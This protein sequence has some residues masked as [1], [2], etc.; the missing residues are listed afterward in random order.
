MCNP[1]ADAINKAFLSDL[2]KGVKV[3]PTVMYDSL[4]N[5]IVVAANMI[6]RKGSLPNERTESS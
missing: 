3:E 5:T 6:R 2:T 4:V 1:S